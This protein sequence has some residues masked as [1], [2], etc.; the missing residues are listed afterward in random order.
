MKSELR[1]LCIPTSLLVASS[2]CQWN[3]NICCQWNCNL[4]VFFGWKTFRDKNI[5]NM[6]ELTLWLTSHHGKI[7]WSIWGQSIVPGCKA[8]DCRFCNKDQNLLHRTDFLHP[9]EQNQIQNNR[10]LEYLMGT[11]HFTQYLLYKMSTI[12]RWKLPTTVHLRIMSMLGWLVLLRIDSRTPLRSSLAKGS[13]V[14][15]TRP[16]SLSSMT[17]L[18]MSLKRFGSLPD[19]KAAATFCAQV[20]TGR[21]HDSMVIVIRF[22]VVGQVGKRASS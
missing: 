17:V 15:V 3:C 10:I 8:L 6:N 20:V 14:P 1:F 7:M 9:L 22:M 4:R 5:L 13:E 16:W 12:N 21:Y 2:D 19:N 18:I 11:A